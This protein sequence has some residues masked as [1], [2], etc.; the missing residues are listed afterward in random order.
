MKPNSKASSEITFRHSTSIAVVVCG[1][2][3]TGCTVTEVRNYDGSSTY[4]VAP[5]YSGSRVL[6]KTGGGWQQFT[7]KFGDDFHALAAFGFLNAVC[8]SD[9]DGAFDRTAARSRKAGKTGLPRFRKF[10]ENDWP[11]RDAAQFTIVSSGGGKVVARVGTTSGE[12]RVVSFETGN[13]GDTGCGVHI[14]AIHS[15]STFR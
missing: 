13:V 4:R 14:K 6:A 5:N 9:L 7:Q 10:I 3:L 15:S 11:L 8:S 2:F 12:V 1:L